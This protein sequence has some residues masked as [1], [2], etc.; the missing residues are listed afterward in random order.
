MKPC[1]ELPTIEELP[2]EIGDLLKLLPPLNAFRMMAATPGSFRGFLDLAGAVLSGA[3]F[4]AKQREIAVL[5]V[6]R[7]L[8]CK[9]AW[10]HHVT[11]GKMTGLTDKEISAIR[12]EDPVRS[13]DEE[14]NLLCRTADEITRNVRLGQE[15]LV[16]IKSRYG[17]KSA[18]ALILCCSYFNMLGRCLESMRVPLETGDVDAQIKTVFEKPTP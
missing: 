4:D 11:V 18:A 8:D 17:N 9:Y 15:T 14:G 12:N 2:Q 5:R 6:V 16:K 3:E 7:V 10:T 13:L 1:I